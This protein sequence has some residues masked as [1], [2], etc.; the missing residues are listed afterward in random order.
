MR[1]QRN[2]GQMQLAVVDVY[3]DRVQ[4]TL[5]GKSPAAP[6]GSIGF[7]RDYVVGALHGLTKSCEVGFYVRQSSLHYFPS[8]ISM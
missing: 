8:K 3:R 7:Y 6:G 5:A 4:M 2:H 1:I